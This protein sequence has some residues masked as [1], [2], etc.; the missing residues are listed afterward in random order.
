MKQL[1]INTWARKEHFDFYNE[2]SDPYFNVCVRINVK[3]VFEYAKRSKTSFYQCYLFAAMKAVNGY[4]P[5]RLRIKDE[6]VFDVPNIELSTVQIAPDDSFRIAY[7]PFSDSLSEYSELCDAAFESA[8]SQNFF[9]TQFVENEGRINC[10]YV[11]VLPWLDFSSFSHA[12]HHGVNDGIPKLVFGK[13]DADTGTMPLSIE[14]HHAL[15]D[16]LHVARFVDELQ[17]QCGKF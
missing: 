8:L 15:M 11:S 3:P 12:S 7:L 2:F 10:V 16:G 17:T 14:V 9:S 6:C 1:D 5:M 4:Q 13:Y